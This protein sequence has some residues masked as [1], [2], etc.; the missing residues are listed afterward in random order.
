MIS[1]FFFHCAWFFGGG[2]WHLNNEKESIVAHLFIGWLDMWF[3]PFFFW[4]RAWRRGFPLD[5]A[6]TDSI[7]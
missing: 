4:F 3:I 2:E 1:V 5:P 6:R 7:Y